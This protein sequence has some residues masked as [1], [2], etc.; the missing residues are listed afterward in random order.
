MPLH[1]ECGVLSVLATHRL[2]HLYITMSLLLDSG[3][4]G[5]VS[6]INLAHESWELDY[7]FRNGRDWELRCKWVG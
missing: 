3:L 2:P 4:G 7:E 1:M 5:E 6:L